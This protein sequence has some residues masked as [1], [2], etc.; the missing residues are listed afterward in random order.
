MKPYIVILGSNSYD[1]FI[2]GALFSKTF[3]PSGCVGIGNRK[4][5]DLIRLYI[6][7]E[8]RHKDSCRDVAE[9]LRR[10]LGECYE[11]INDLDINKIYI[12]Q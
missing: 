8:K 10:E 7:Y 6:T 12:G 1:V 9:R 11:V 5:G 2:H 3:T 4:S